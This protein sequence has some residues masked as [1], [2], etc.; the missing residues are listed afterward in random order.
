[1]SWAEP[2]RAPARAHCREGL[3]AVVT[4]LYASAGTCVMRLTTVSSRRRG[5]EVVIGDD[6]LRAAAKG[7]QALRRPPRRFQ[8][9]HRWPARR[10]LTAR[11]SMPSCSSMLPLN[12]PW[13]WWR[14]QVASMM[15]S[16]YCSR[17]LAG[18]P[19]RPCIGVVQVVQAEFKEDLAGLGFP[20]GMFQQGWNVWQAQR[21]AD[22][23]ERPWSA[24]LDRR[25]TQGNTGATRSG[26]ALSGRSRGQPCLPF[27]QDGGRG[28]GADPRAA[29]LVDLQAWSTCALRPRL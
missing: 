17:K 2:W 13:F 6:D 5:F 23:G 1:M 19:P 10:A 26:P 21:D 27:V 18:L 24:P 16:G 3:R 15:Q 28:S 9:R 7:A 4:I 29:R 12:L 22:A 25:D 14:R 20:P 8:S 11:S